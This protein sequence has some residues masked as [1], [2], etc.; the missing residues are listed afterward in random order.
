[1]DAKEKKEVTIRENEQIVDVE[2]TENAIKRLIYV[3]RR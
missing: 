2:I 1:M 3:V